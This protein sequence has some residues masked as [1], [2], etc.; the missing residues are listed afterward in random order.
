VGTI[1]YSVINAVGLAVL[2]AWTVPESAL[3]PE[4]ATMYWSNALSSV[5]HGWINNPSRDSPE[6]RC[7][8]FVLINLLSQSS[9]VWTP[10]LAFLTVEAPRY[11]KEYSFC[12][13]RGI[14][15]IASTWIM[16]YY[17]KRDTQPEKGLD[18]IEIDGGSGTESRMSNGYDGKA[19]KA[20]TT[21]H[22]ILAGAVHGGL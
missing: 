6:E 15:L 7:F 20:D 13:G 4:F 11:R 19:L 5:F 16:H 9:T 14:M 8:T 2:T 17:H 3:G 12:L 1:K 21:A 10:L 22:G 18:A